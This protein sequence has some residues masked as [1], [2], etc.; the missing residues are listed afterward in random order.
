VKGELEHDSGSEMSITETLNWMMGWLKYSGGADEISKALSA[1]EAQE[2]M[3]PD[4]YLEPANPDELDP[5]IWKRLIPAYEGA[6]KSAGANRGP[7]S[8]KGAKP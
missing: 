6:L 1:I 5:E 4:L 3:S 8:V 7:K 2:V